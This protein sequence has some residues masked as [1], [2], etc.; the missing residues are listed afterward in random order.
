MKQLSTRTIA[1]ISLIA[2]AILALGV[3]SVQKNKEVPVPMPIPENQEN[4]ENQG[5]NGGDMT[6]TINTSDWQT[7]RNEEL[8]FEVKYPGDIYNVKDDDYIPMVSFNAVT[9]ELKEEYGDIQVL[10]MGGIPIQP[11]NEAKRRSISDNYR[12]VTLN[13]KEMYYS[14]MEF[15]CSKYSGPEYCHVP[16]SFLFISGEKYFDV[17][18]ITFNDVES[19]ELWESVFINF[20]STFEMF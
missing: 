10:Y 17:R 1:I 3:F 16:G 14:E 7:Y 8:G 19:P 11:L 12:L 20:I 2:I 13:N 15:D 4:Q 5:G 18:R 6:E 9:R